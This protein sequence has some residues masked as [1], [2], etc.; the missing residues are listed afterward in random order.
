MEISATF[1]QNPHNSAYASGVSSIPR[2]RLFTLSFLY[3][4]EPRLGWPLHIRNATMTLPS[5]GSLLVCDSR[6]SCQYEI[7]ITNNT[8]NASDFQNIKLPSKGR[9]LTKA[10]GLRLYDPGM[11]NTAIKK[12]QITGRYACYVSL[13]HSSTI[14][15]Y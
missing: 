15:N 3:T 5:E 12:T 13:I 9:S 14:T 8:V 11:Q 4:S 1:S 10:S 6:T 7:P 2:A